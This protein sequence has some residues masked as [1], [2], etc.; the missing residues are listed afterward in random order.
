[1]GYCAN[2]HTGSEVVWIDGQTADL[3][4]YTLGLVRDLRMRTVGVG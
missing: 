3:W 1:M 2:R 4:L